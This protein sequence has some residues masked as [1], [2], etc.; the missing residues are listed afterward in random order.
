MVPVM[1]AGDGRDFAAAEAAAEESAACSEPIDLVLG[2][3]KGYK[4][5]K[6]F[7]VPLVRVGF[8]IHDRFGGQRVKLLS[9]AGTQELFDRI[10]NAII[11]RAQEESDVGYT[12]Y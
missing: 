6:R 2:S 8:P 5:A 10:V 9:Y 4:T 1:A 12:Y 11:E 7:N 3:S